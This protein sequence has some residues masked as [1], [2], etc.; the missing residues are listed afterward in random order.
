MVFPGIT[1]YSVAESGTMRKWDVQC[2]V[3][4]TSI[5]NRVAES[6]FVKEEAGGGCQRQG[7]LDPGGLMSQAHAMLGSG[8]QS[9][10]R[11]GLK[12][13]THRT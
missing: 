1:C 8:P 10:G 2:T 6:L 9:K 11:S 7:R 12:M 13:C 4:E 3:Q 5:E